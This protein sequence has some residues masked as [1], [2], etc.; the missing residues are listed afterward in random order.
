MWTLQ[1][2]RIASFTMLEDTR[3]FTNGVREQDGLFTGIF[4]A[5]CLRLIILTLFLQICELLGRRFDLLSVRVHTRI[6]GFGRQ[7]R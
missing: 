6:D 1:L 7:L 3:K 4:D 2:D 5:A